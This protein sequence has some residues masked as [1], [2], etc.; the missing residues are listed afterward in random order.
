MGL[1]MKGK[2]ATITLYVTYLILAITIVLIAGFAAPLGVRF[3]SEIY[4]AGEGIL[5]DANDSI[6]AINDADMRNQIYSVID[7][8]YQAGENNI[9]VNANLFQYS[10]ILIIG[11]TAIVIFLYSRRLVEY[12]GLV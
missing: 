1:K 5:L 10:W 7:E 9:E 2:K 6:A 3:N 11:I 12:G 4:A 8:A